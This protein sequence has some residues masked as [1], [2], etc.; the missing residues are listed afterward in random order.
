MF[1]LI[2]A[3][4][5]Q[6]FIINIFMRSLKFTTLLSGVGLLDHIIRAVSGDALDLCRHYIKFGLQVVRDFFE[7]EK[8]G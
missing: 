3:F 6:V 1:V 2:L 7:C 8:L 5:R 4:W